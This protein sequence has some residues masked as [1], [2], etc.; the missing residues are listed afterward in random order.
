MSTRFSR[1]ISII[2]I[3]VAAAIIATA[4]VGIS[5]AWQLYI[6][7]SN[8]SAEYAQAANLTEEAGEALDIMRDMS[9]NSNISP[10]SLGTT[11]Y[12]YWNGQS[13]TATT[14]PQI[15]NS[16]YLRTIVLSSI[17]RDANYN[18]ASSGTLDPNTKLATI[19]VTISGNASTT[20]AQLQTLIHNVFNN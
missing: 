5:G 12:L 3:V 15:I 19:T 6:K 16:T 8:I 2:E 4:V 9:W 7:V 10:L 18:I 1:G 17:N 11:Y 14:T 20:L 13:Y